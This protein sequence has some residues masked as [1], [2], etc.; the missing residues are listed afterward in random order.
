MPGAKSSERAPLPESAASEFAAR[1]GQPPRSPGSPAGKLS[2]SS[3]ELLRVQRPQAFQWQTDHVLP[4]ALDRQRK[5][6]ART[7]DRVAARAS[8]PLARGE[9][10]AHQLTVD[11]PK[12][13]PR[14][15]H[16]RTLD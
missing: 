13:D 14:T 6:R 12:G 9:V 8:A 16:C 11:V 4:L 2:G 10:G 15:R 7:L 5:R 3:A 1:I